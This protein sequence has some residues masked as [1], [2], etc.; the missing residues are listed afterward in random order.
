LPMRAAMYLRVSHDPHQRGRS[1]A[2]QEADCRLI[3]EREGWEVVKKFTDND[4]GASRYAK[5]ERTAFKQLQAFVS[6]GKCDVLV[7]WEA[8]RFQRDLDA[9]V[10]LRDLC[11]KHNVLWSYSGRLYDLSE[12]DDRFTTG[13]DA[14]LAER[15]AGETRK[16]VLRA[17]R[18]NAAAGKP[19][20]RIPY[21]YERE[22][23][24]ATG[25]LLRQVVRKD[26]AAVVREAARRLIAG[27]TCNA[28]ATD[29]NKRGLPVSRNGKWDLTR[30]RRLVT[31]PAYIAKRVHQGKIVGDAVW[32]PILDEQTFYQCAAI[33][34]DPARKSTNEHAV[35]YLL[36][37]IATCGVCGNTLKVQPQR[38]FYKTYLCRKFCTARKLEWVDEFVEA[39]MLA[40]L[41]KPDALSLFADGDGD[42]SELLNVIADKRARLDGFYDAASAGEI[43]PTA[44]G[45]IEGTLL[46][47]IEALESKVTRLDVSP[48][49]YELAERPNAVWPKLSLE[50][51]REAIRCLITVRILPGHSGSK[52]FDPKTVQVRW[53]G[54]REDVTA[55]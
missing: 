21:G 55:A 33:V 53:R 44:L 32:K 19:H 27:E 54:S 51:K 28:I 41:S 4:R 23:D 12:N 5:G 6:S 26:Q 8:S 29:F 13:L 1:V 49:V 37:G 48:I 43:T 22:Y 25:E 30:V 34:N 31:N 15:E 40:R 18:A 11:S 24:K 46:Q 50:Q 3:A 7:C 39:V 38:N 16:R 45:R 52:S 35:K 2:E 9:Y 36:S 14:L 47:E 42:N 20:G 17:V 10:K